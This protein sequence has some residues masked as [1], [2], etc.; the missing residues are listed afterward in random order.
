VAIADADDDDLAAAAGRSTGST[1]LRGRVEAAA[2]GAEGVD[3][4]AKTS[5]AR[6][7]CHGRRC[8]EVTAD[9]TP[10]ISDGK[11]RQVWRGGRAAAAEGVVATERSGDGAGVSGAFWQQ[12]GAGSLAFV[13]TDIVGSTQLKEVLERDGRKPDPGPHTRVRELLGFPDA[14]GVRTAGDSSSC[15]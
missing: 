5:R 9:A 7:R 13:F 15:S 3:S 10:R 12:H 14:E 2:N 6:V 11:C 4:I 8:R 1:T